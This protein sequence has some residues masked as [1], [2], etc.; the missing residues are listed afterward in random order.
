MRKVEKLRETLGKTCKDCEDKNV[1][2]NS[3][4]IVNY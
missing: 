1:F 4:T 3:N 2:G